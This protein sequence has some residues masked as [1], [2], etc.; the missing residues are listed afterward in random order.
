MRM[1]SI[2][3]FF[4]LIMAG[5]TQ[6]LIAAEAV[7]ALPY[8][9]GGYL[10]QIDLQNNRVVINDTIFEIAPYLIV[11]EGPKKGTTMRREGLKQG[12]YVGFNVIP[13]SPRAPYIKEMWI[14]ESE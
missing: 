8:Q 2:I 13:Q 5:T 12:M 9:T 1:K 4:C 11:H 14:V 10:E 3:V 7:L 6:P